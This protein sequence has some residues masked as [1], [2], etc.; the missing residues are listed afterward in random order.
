MR[1][2]RK[3]QPRSAQSCDLAYQEQL[4]GRMLAVRYA[5]FEGGQSAGHCDTCR[6]PMTV[7]FRLRSFATEAL[8]AGARFPQ[9]SW[10]CASD[11][12][13]APC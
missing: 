9:T 8:Q 1:P 6:T 10:R 4:P 13:I 2:L 5:D 7:C 12:L 11:M 3:L